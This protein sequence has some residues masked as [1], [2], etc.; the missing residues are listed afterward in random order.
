M[1]LEPVAQ[2]V[3]TAVFG[4]VMPKMDRDIAA[5]GVDHQPRDGERADPADAARFEDACLLFERFE[6]AD[7]AADDHAAAVEL[8]FGKIEPRI[9]DR[10]DGGGHAELAK[11][12]QPLGFAN[13]RPRIW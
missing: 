9:F 2:A 7:A 1:A 3:A 8:F 5:G 13:D 4:P 6:P 10:A 11:P 12:I